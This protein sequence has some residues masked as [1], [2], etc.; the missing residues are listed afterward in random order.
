MVISVRPH[1][2]VFPNP[3]LSPSRPHY[4]AISFGIAGTIR[5]NCHW[6][7]KGATRGS[8]F[9]AAQKRIKED[10]QTGSSRRPKRQEKGYEEIGKAFASNFASSETR[11][12]KRGFEASTFAPRAQRCKETFGRCA[13]AISEEGGKDTN[14]IGFD[15]T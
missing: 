6:S 12:E 9:A 10:A 3:L 5:S 13:I 14:E 4:N 15:E 1:L 8:G 7:I 2:P 11:R